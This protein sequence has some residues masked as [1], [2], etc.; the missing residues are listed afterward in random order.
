MKVTLYMA[1]SIDGYIA[2]TNMSTKWVSN[3]D[4]E[5]LEKKIQNHKWVILWNTTFKEFGI[6]PRVH[7][8]VISGKKNNSKTWEIYAQDIT[9]ALKIC[10]N[11][12]L[13]NPLLIWGGITNASFLEENKIEEIIISIHPII[14]WKGVKIFENIE[15]EQ[16]LILWEIKKYDD[17]LVHLYYMVKK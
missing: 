9:Q 8:I 14:L 6:T 12:W 4:F 11:L 7:N 10:N 2:K 16:K 3:V 5:I 17:D 1:T 15:V 13:E